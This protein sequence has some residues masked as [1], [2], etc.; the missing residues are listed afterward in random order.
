MRKGFPSREP[1]IELPFLTWRVRGGAEAIA[2]SRH[3][4]IHRQGDRDQFGNASRS[5]IH[6]H[7]EVLPAGYDGH[8]EFRQETWGKLGFKSRRKASRWNENHLLEF[9]E[10]KIHAQALDDRPTRLKLRLKKS[11]IILYCARHEIVKMR[12][13][14]ALLAL[15]GLTPPKTKKIKPGVEASTGCNCAFRNCSLW[16]V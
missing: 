16:R 5:R 14:P 3:L 1:D 7:A 9:L 15:G 12:R 2:D 10:G 13:I 11:K 6:R 4:P 8:I